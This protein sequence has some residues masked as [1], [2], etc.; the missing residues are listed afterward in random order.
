MRVM[1]YVRPADSRHW[2]LT[3]GAWGASLAPGRGG[4]RSEGG[5][6]GKAAGN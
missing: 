2:L 4:T 3:S 5:Q 6:S 1:G